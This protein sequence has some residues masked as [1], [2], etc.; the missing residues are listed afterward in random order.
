MKLLVTAAICALGCGIWGLDSGAVSAQERSLPDTKALFRAVREN[1][2]RAERETHLYTYMERRTDIHTN[3]FGRLGT[4]GTSVYEVYPSPVRRLVYR[5]LV[6][7]D[8]MRVSAEQLAEQDRE[9]RRL[10]LDVQE[11]MAA[12]DPADARVVE[13]ESQRARERR[14]R[15][16]DDVVDTL[17]FEVT[18]RT[19]YK[20]VPAILIAFTPKASASPSTRQ[21]R[22]AEKFAGTIWVHEAAREV[23][24]VEATSIGAISYGYG[25]LA[26]LGEGTTVTL[27]RQPV[28]GGLWMPTEL[29]MTGRGRAVLFRRLVVDFA[30]EWSDY[31]RLPV[32]SLAPFVDPRIQRQPGGGPQ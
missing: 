9:Y 22:I 6:A 8:G 11:E 28:E 5:R 13:A 10:V 3:P 31:R 21:G 16:M 26:R 4:G 30:I 14:Q 2:V 7:R 12:R 27:T 18:G 24:Y 15:A 32:E 25:I 29:T 19:I 1:L 20:G 17:S 23:M